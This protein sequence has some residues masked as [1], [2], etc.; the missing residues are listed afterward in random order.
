MSNFEIISILVWRQH[1]DGMGMYSCQC[2]S[3]TLRLCCLVQVDKSCGHSEGNLNR[4]LTALG[5]KIRT[6]VSNVSVT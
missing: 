5:D 3:V 2:I 1:W 4:R 6:A